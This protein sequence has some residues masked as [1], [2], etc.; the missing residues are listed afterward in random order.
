MIML[1]Y[2][3]RATKGQ[4]RQ[5]KEAQSRCRAFTES[6]D[7]SDQNLTTFIRGP[8]ATCRTFAATPLVSDSAQTA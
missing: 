3:S 5:K 8:R 4:L 6:S 7:M 2:Y 1:S